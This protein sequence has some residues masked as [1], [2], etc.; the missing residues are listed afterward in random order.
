MSAAAS[1][2]A[3]TSLKAQRARARDATRAK[4]KDLPGRAPEE[5]PATRC[6]A[7][8]SAA[9]RQTPFNRMWSTGRFHRPRA[10]VGFLV[11]GSLQCPVGALS[12]T[13]WREQ[14][15]PVRHGAGHQRLAAAAAPAAL[16]LQMRTTNV[17]PRE[18]V[19]PVLCLPP[20]Q[21]RTAGLRSRARGC[22]GSHAEILPSMP[23]RV[24]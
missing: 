15:Q 14:P 21:P 19:I 1:S 18:T 7:R 2:A 16:R 23:C 8:R 10:A 11:R 20:A 22:A 3:S 9:P 24:A 12:A 4:R 17:G 5:A 13:E 6:T